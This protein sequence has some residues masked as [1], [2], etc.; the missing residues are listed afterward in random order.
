[1]V[2]KGIQYACLTLLCTSQPYIFIPVLMFRSSKPIPF[3]SSASSPVKT[4]VLESMVRH[5]PS[6]LNSLR[7]NIFIETNYKRCIYADKDIEI[8]VKYQQ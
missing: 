3:I 8:Y 1:M 6:L 2:N 7:Q 4:R 5:N